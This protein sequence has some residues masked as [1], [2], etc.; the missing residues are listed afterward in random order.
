MALDNEQ[1]TQ[2]RL[3]KIDGKGREYTVEYK[4]IEGGVCAA[5]GF[6]A[7]GLNCGLNPVKEKNDLGLIYSIKECDAAAVYTQNKVKGAPILVTKSNLEKTGGKARAVIVNS[8]NANTCNADGEE[9]AWQMCKLA[10]DALNLKPEEIMV[11]STGVIGQILPIE[12]IADHVQE[13]ADGLTE[14]GNE[15]AATAI[16]TTDTVKKEVAVTFELNGKTCCLGGMAKGSG[17]IHPNMATTLNFITTDVNISA[18]LLQKALSEIVK[19]T[20]NCLSVDGDTSTND[21]VC[22]LANGLAGNE[23]INAE[24]AEYEIFKGA[25]YQVMMQMTKML[26]KD[27]EGASK[28]LECTC[29]GAPDLDTAIIVAK[30]VIR[31]PLFKCAMFGEDANW[32]RILCAIGYAEADFDIT[33]VSVDLASEKGS[34]H[35]CE[36]GAGVPFSEDEAKVVLSADEIYI[37]IDLHQGDTTAKAWGCDLTYDYV[38]INGDYRS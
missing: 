10:A 35:V 8:K 4:T 16:M 30:S 5:K 18:E 23:K 29:A 27:G 32:G 9:K 3:R 38:K 28:L 11:A 21:M 15:R 36:N 26:A 17:M 20:Y 7:N 24:T 1:F 37:Q 12:P 14:N 6:M 2:E 22:L 34:I 31:S 25:L 13:L 19:V 33:K